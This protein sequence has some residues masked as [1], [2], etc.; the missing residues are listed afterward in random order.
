MNKTVQ[1]RQK[2]GDKDYAL[3]PDR[4]KQFREDNPRADISTAE[5][6]N[7][8][9]SIT[10]RA[11]IVKDLS[12]KHSARATGTAR[13]TSKEME[14]LKAFEKL[15]T[16]SVGRALAML[17]YLNDGQVATTEE[18]EE[19]EN[20]KEDKALNALVDEALAALGAAKTE[21][22]LREAFGKYPKL[23]SNP[24]VVA[25]KDAKKKELSDANG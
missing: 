2:F 9:G 8:D 13:Y 15:E 4:I 16:I 10:F 5:T 6:Y 17:G 12:D 18:I 25:A 3:V 11:T 14:K 23:W 1:T 19:F 7:P 22:D 24:N 20:Y 21:S